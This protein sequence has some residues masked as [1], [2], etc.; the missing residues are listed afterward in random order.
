MTAKTRPAQAELVQHEAHEGMVL[1]PQGVETTRR[2]DREG[3]GESQGH[4]G[5]G[6]GQRA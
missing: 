2:G 5:P 6:E 3:Q 1:D 4:D